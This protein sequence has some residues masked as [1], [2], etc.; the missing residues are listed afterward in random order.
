MTLAAC[1]G[2]DTGTHKRRRLFH[3]PPSPFPACPLPLLRQRS[4]GGGEAGD[5]HAVLLEGLPAR[6][7]VSGRWVTSGGVGLTSV[8]SCLSP[9]TR[10]RRPC[11]DITR[12]PWRLVNGKP[13]RTYFPDS[14]TCDPDAESAPARLRVHI[15]GWR[16]DARHAIPSHTGLEG[17]K[18]DELHHHNRNL[19]RRRHLADGRG[20]TPSPKAPTGGSQR[21]R[22]EGMTDAF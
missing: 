2:I 14:R 9:G 7:P 5:G 18:T 16:A 20:T 6:P 3:G 17:T 15:A 10:K 22:N 1:N 19:R 4:L 8:P 12:A 21:Q 13:L 11:C